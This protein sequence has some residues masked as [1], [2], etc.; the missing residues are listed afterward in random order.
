MAT[1]KHQAREPI[2]IDIILV[3]R[4]VLTSRTETNMT[5]QSIIE[6]ASVEAEAQ[7]LRLR[8]VEQSLSRNDIQVIFMA[9]VVALLSRNSEEPVMLDLF[10]KIESEVGAIVGQIH[11][12]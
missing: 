8:G 3:C 7:V 10:D 2:D 11:T 12:K 6:H 5:L 4:K 9:Q 1:P